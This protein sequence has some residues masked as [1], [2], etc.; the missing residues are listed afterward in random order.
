MLALMIDRGDAGRIGE[1]A[2]R[3]VED[4]RAVVLV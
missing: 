4:Q 1:L 2:A 3:L